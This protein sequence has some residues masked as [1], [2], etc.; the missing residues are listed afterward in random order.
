M[1]PTQ[2]RSLVNELWIEGI[3]E[4]EQEVTWFQAY[5]PDLLDAYRALA[6]LAKEVNHDA[7][8]GSRVSRCV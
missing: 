8:A 1:T 7:S 2:A 3:L 4:N 6:N 5:K